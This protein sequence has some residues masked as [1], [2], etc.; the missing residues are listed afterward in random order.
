[1]KRRRSA[2]ALGLAALLG[3]CGAAKTISTEQLVSDITTA[4]QDDYGLEAQAVTCPPSV[5]VQEGDSFDCEVMLDGGVLTITV[6]QTDA[7]GTLRFVAADAVVYLADVVDRIQRQFEQQRGRRVTV[8]CGDGEVFVGQADD[9][10]ECTLR[11]RAGASATMTVTV[12]GP[13]GDVSFDLPV[14]HKD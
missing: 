5:E 11:D 2:A 12:L 4:M 3:A 6:V 8:E 1:M 10:F 9:A 14:L 7:E 13:K